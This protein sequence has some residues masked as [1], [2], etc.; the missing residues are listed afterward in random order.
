[1]TSRFVA[2]YSEIALKGNNR[3]EFVSALRRN[4]NRVLAGVDHTLEHSGGRFFIDAEADEAD[5]SQRLSRVFGL[6]WFAPVDVLRQDYGSILGAVMEAAGASPAKSFKISSRRPDKT[7]PMGSQELAS[8]LGA[9][10]VEGTGKTVD[11]AE[12]ELTIHVDVAAGKALVYENKTRGLGGLPV[13]TAGRVIHLFSGGIDSPV[14]AWLLMKRGARP[15][16][17]HFYLAPTPAAALESK[18]TRLVKVLSAYQGKTTLV[19]VPFA[20]YQIAAGGAPG[21]LEPSLF[22]RFMRMTAEALSRSFGAVAV[23]TGDSLSQAASQT[24]WNMGSFDAGASLPVLRPLLSYDK[25]EIIS[26]ARRI[27][28]YDLSI[29]EYKD[30]CAMITKHPRTRV[31]SEEIGA[32]VDRLG[33]RALVP[34]V[35]RDATLVSYN[36]AGD[37]LR[38]TPLDGMMDEDEAGREGAS[39]PEPEAEL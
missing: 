32:Q 39:P 13:G 20:E 1:M 22:R 9:A 31:R 21:E 6:S 11:L 34:R 25:D 24:L 26:L 35:I 37:L 4:L 15:V 19:L 8:R 10:V 36:P 18:I 38:A 12:P 28:T 27:G 23:S 5:V 29:E 7:F 3:R 30:C 16:Y 33:L 14:A 17:L 2:H